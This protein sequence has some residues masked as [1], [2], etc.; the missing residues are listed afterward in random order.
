MKLITLD[1]LSFPYQDMEQI[2]KI[3]ASVLRKNIY[4]PVLKSI[5]LPAAGSLTNA[6]P[7]D[8]EALMTALQSGRITY[9]RGIFSGRFSAAT[10]RALKSLGASWKKSK[11]TFHLPMDKMPEDLQAEV[12]T[13]QSR[14]TQKLQ[15]VD[16]ALRQILPEEVASTVHVSDLFDKTIFKVQKEFEDNV[17]G[18][19]ITPTLSEYEREKISKEWQENLR[20]YIKSFTEKEI[21]QLREK[22]RETVFAGDR[23][24]SL[25]SVIK[26]SY[27]VSENK[28]AF[29][30]RQETKLLVVKF[31]E[32]RYT[33]AG[34]PGYLWQN[35][36]GTPLHPVRPRHKQLGDMS[37]KGQ[38][39]QWSDP[40]VTTEP[41]EP[42]RR[43][44]PGQDY[45]CRCTARPVVRVG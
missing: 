23:Y 4:L 24:G 8:T 27:G 34:I 43:N 42:E 5:G 18:I 44:N 38:I 39:F 29:L 36:M 41:G 30:A 19:K 37:R 31:Q 25:M 9:N 12:L 33:Q 7:Q 22:V 15:K 32:S 3:I 45:N 10:S 6:S 40:P 16:S 17:G 11:S 1:P 13:T 20:L 2:E 28:A 35:V 21:L 26:T 14:F